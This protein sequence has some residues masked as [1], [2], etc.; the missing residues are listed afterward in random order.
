[1][2]I[3]S[4]G[5]AMAR[6][7][8][9]II[10]AARL[11]WPLILGG[12]CC[13]I[14]MRQLDGLN[15]ATVT[16][17]LAQVPPLH[18]L[19]AIL[20]TCLSFLAVARYDVIALRHFGLSRAQG[21]A[22]YTGAIAIALGQ[23]L[24]AGPLVGSFVRWRLMPDLSI[25]Q[26][27]RVSAFVALTFLGALAV[28]ISVCVMFQPVRLVPD[29]VV[30]AILGAALF[31][32]GRA[33]ITPTLRLRNLLIQLPTLPAIAAIL[34]YCLLDTVFA[35]LALHLLM[36]ATLDLSF[37]TLLPVFLIALGAA[38]LSGTP[39]G[40]GP[41][42]LSMIALLPAVPAPEVMAGILG[43]RAIYYALPALL[44][45]VTLL[46]NLTG[47]RTTQPH[48]AQPEQQ[49]FLG[50]I[51]KF[52]PGRAEL[53]V[54]AQSQGTMFR[55]HNGTCG[56]LRTTQTLTML[57]DPCI[58]T[59]DKLCAPLQT[60]ARAQ[61]RVPCAYKISARQA[62]LARTAAWSVI[63]IADEAFVDPNRHSLT[64]PPYR[65]LR[66]KLRHAQKAGVEPVRVRGPLPFGEMQRVSL[67]WEARHGIARGLTMGR[68]EKGYVARQ[69]VYCAYIG[70]RLLG[71]V[72]FHTSEPEWCL[73]L[74]RVVPDAPDGTTH[75]LVQSAIS[76]AAMLAIPRVSLAA[77]P[78]R[79]SEAK[80]VKNTVRKQVFTRGGGPGL[81]Q[82]KS[83][84]APRWAPLYMAA[85]TNLH[86][87]SAIADLSLAVH[88]PT[89]LVATTTPP[90]TC[91]HAQ[92]S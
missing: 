3:P 68:L 69:R 55:H 44:A 58:G 74:I 86:L 23:T 61:N 81:R 8:R 39:G 50:D 53:G 14:L 15:I 47:K 66:R 79:P 88:R 28:V 1:M 19:G 34:A 18:W 92:N 70:A 22:M 13:V 17:S 11:V 36:P 64:G 40:V 7:G 4:A 91:Q 33:M 89:Q 37:A 56:V 83:C 35:A 30:W 26:A 73:D 77:A 51:S 75:L 41:F 5:R 10:G 71:F 45:G 29:L 27:A 72:S 57:F 78:A 62:A 42:E 16:H 48:A 54:L 87:V 38:I 60:A 85:P 84:F 49:T 43:F 76:D 9:R 32:I 31:L 65:Q 63:H 20:C 82:F 25:A 52:T 21:R 2:N 24:G 12:I 67:L 80:S 90:Q 59:L 46:I 6:P